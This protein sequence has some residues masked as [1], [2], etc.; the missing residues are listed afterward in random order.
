MSAAWFINQEDGF[1]FIFFIGHNPVQFLSWHTHPLWI[2]LKKA[3]SCC[4]SVSVGVRQALQL[5][6][7]TK[8]LFCPRGH[9]R[10]IKAQ[11][12]ALNMYLIPHH[13]S[14]DGLDT[15]RP[16]LFSLDLFSVACS[17]DLY[18]QTRK[19]LLTK[20]VTHA[21]ALTS[22]MRVHARPPRPAHRP[23]SAPST[24]PPTFSEALLG[25]SFAGPHSMHP[26]PST[27]S[28]SLHP[29]KLQ[30][31]PPTPCPPLPPHPND[32]RPCYLYHSPMAT[33]ACL[34]PPTWRLMRQRHPLAIN[35]TFPTHPAPTPEG[36]Q[37]AAAGS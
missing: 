22:D 3:P 23:P 24:S 25:A 7:Q 18:T 35:R 4:S 33:A 36:D 5:H 17:L 21:C 31:P 26:S 8:Y 29:P 10:Q 9:L 28:P 34:T 1:L 19:L 37:A 12:R 11:D 20:A 6:C 14:D 15:P 13:V 32:T 16:Y 30:P 27:L 2:L